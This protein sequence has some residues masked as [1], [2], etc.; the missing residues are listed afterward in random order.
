MILF[1]VYIFSASL[2]SPSDS[3]HCSVTS[4]ESH[5]CSPF[6][7]SQAGRNL[8]AGVLKT[9]N[10]PEETASCISSS[11]FLQRWWI[12]GGNCSNIKT[13]NLNKVKLTFTAKEK[14][15]PNHKP[16]PNLQCLEMITRRIEHCCSSLGHSCVHC[17]LYFSMFVKFLKIIWTENCDLVVVSLGRGG[18]YSRVSGYTHLDSG[19]WT[20]ERVL[21]HWKNHKQKKCKLQFFSAV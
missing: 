4:R 12:L 2:L 7:A 21:G 14:K 17:W 8:E 10:C 11:S 1:V 6:V 18:V 19:A 15:K 20:E 5:Q 3:W 13:N 16:T 9:L